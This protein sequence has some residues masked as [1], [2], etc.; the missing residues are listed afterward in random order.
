MSKHQ[1]RMLREGQQASAVKLSVNQTSTWGEREEEETRGEMIYDACHEED[2]SLWSDL[3]GLHS[4][5]EPP[6]SSARV[7]C[8]GMARRSFGGEAPSTVFLPF[9]SSSSDGLR[10]EGVVALDRSP[11]KNALPGGGLP[12]QRETAAVKAIGLATSGGARYQNAE[13]IALQRMFSE[14]SNAD[15]VTFLTEAENQNASLQLAL[16]LQK[17]EAAAATGLR[18]ALRHQ[19][20]TKRKQGPLD[21]FLLKKVKD[22]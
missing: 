4:S 20:E 11:I 7:H 17:E 9:T 13:A 5:K 15:A 12:G 19:K 14:E 1:E 8:E 16:R 18:T 22:N 6:K 21:A 2:G 3:A 10:S